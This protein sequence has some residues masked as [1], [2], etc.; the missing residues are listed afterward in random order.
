MS[1]SLELYRAVIGAFNSNKSITP[2]SNKFTVLFKALCSLLAFFL[3]ASKFVGF[4][5]LFLVN[6]LLKSASI[7]KIIL[8]FLLTIFKSNK[9]DKSPS[10]STQNTMND[11][12]NFLLL[13]IIT[14]IAGPFFIKKNISKLYLRFNSPILKLIVLYYNFKFA[15]NLFI[16]GDVE[17]NPGPISD[18]HFKFMHWNPNSIVAHNFHRVSLIQAY[19]AI[20]DFHIISITESALNSKISNE[21]ID[22]PGYIPIRNDL[23]ENDS[24]GGVLI[25]HKI[26]LPVKIRTDI[27]NYSNTLVLEFSIS[28]KKNVC[29]RL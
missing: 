18:D 1:V 3:L 9:L 17:L 13:A 14:D 20:H 24:H 2:S 4:I 27:Q 15:E 28:R 21:S 12:T 6:F 29:P 10:I 16:C 11:I 19:N 26:D 5:G 8:I 7:H 23:P 22:I 25:W